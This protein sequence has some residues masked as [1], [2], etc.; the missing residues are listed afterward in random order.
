M[1]IPPFSSKTLSFPPSGF[2]MDCGTNKFHVTID[3]SGNI[4][5]TL[6][7]PPKVNISEGTGMGLL[8]ALTYGVGGAT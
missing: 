3:C 4:V 5:T 8:L 7:T 6:I 2:I 1:A